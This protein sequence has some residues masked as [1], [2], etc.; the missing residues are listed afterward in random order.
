MDIDHEWEILPDHGYLSDENHQI[1]FGKRNNY[2]ESSKGSVFD[3]YFTTEAASWNHNNHH[4][5]HQQQL[6]DHVPIIQLEPRIDDDDDDDEEDTVS[7]NVFFKNNDQFVEMKKD[8]SSP[9]YVS[10]GLVS[11]PSAPPVAGEESSDGEFNIWKWGMSGVGAIFSFGVAAATIC[12]FF[13]GNAHQRNRI[14]HHH[15]HKIR[16]H[17][18]T[19]DDKRLTQVVQHASKLNEAISAVRGVPLSRAHITYGGYYDAI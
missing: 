6:V 11:P 18:Y 12:V 17:F 3:N 1:L 15:R 16:F 9:K 14:H 2:D 10:R 8:S 13:F 5:Q 7:Q 4:H 19:H